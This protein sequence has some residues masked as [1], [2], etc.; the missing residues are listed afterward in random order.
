MPFRLLSFAVIAVLTLVF[1]LGCSS[2]GQSGADEFEI[3]ILRSREL[4]NRYGE[5]QDPRLQAYNQYLCSRLVRAVQRSERE[6][7]MSTKCQMV[8][9]N[10]RAPLAFSLG[11]GK[12]AVSR[13]LIVRMR[14]EAELAFVIAHEIS[15]D[16]LGHEAQIFAV[17]DYLLEQERQ[18]GL[19]LEADRYALGIVALAGYDPRASIEAIVSASGIHDWGTT[20][21]THP[22]IE[23]RHKAAW[24]Q[25][26]KSGWM[27]PGTVEKREF[28][29]IRDLLRA[30]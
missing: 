14:N 11:N 25:F 6:G 12:V 1:G 7:L 16:T 19:E 23:M 2:G 4:R 22:S 5:I 24:N 8:F 9:L 20:A 28:K 10:E 18:I 17:G 27:P 21:G 15:H 29:K 26:E 30:S 13:G 3:S